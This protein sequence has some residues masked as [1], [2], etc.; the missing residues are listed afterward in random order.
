MSARRRVRS[1]ERYGAARSG[2]AKSWKPKFYRCIRVLESAA[3][4]NPTS[5]GGFST[6]QIRALVI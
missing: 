2:L 3:D 5:L 6:D 4:Q 1:P